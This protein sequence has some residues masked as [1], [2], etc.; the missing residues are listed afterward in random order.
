[1]DFVKVNAFIWRCNNTAKEQAQK[2]RSNLPI[3]ETIESIVLVARGVNIV[4]APYKT[5]DCFCRLIGV[6][7]KAVNFL[8]ASK[9]ACQFNCSGSNVP[10]LIT[11]A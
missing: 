6:P 5:A 3:V 8:V 4:R 9:L 2:K 1:M 7:K 10:D 11:C